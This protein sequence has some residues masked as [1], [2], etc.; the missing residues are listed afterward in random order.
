MQSITLLAHGCA[1]RLS[2]GSTFGKRGG[3]SLPEHTAFDMNALVGSVLV[4]PTAPAGEVVDAAE[5]EAEAV[6][7]DGVD[8]DESDY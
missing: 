5:A 7:D 8:D 2:F 4:E 6:L 3:R 1:A